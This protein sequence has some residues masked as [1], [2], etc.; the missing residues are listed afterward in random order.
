MVWCPFTA[1]GT[2]PKTE[3][4]TRDWGIA[5]MGLT[6]LLFGRMQIWGFWIWKAVMGCPTKNMEEIG[7]EDNFNCRSLVL[8]VSEENFNMWPRDYSCDI[9]VKNVAAF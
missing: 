6:V 9:L 1:M 3:V 5:A 8:E 4:G 2:L 7:V